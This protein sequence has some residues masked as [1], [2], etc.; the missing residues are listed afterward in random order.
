MKS[1]T[2]AC[3]LFYRNIR[4]I[5]HLPRLKRVYPGLNPPFHPFISIWRV[6][7]V[8]RFSAIPAHRAHIH[9]PSG[10]EYW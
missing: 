3:A 7:P 10:A 2:L 6:L 9:G 8:T 5:N 1:G 4:E